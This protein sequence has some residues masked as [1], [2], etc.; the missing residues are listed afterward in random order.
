[1]ATAICH[2]LVFTLTHLV[3]TAPRNERTKR[4]QNVARRPDQ[5]IGIVTQNFTGAV[6]NGDGA[7]RRG[8]GGCPLLQWDA[9]RLGEGVSDFGAWKLATAAP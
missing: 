8:F 2:F 3:P 4:R 5:G 1:M 6:F 7:S 9:E